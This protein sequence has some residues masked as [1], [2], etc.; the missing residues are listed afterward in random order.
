MS[1]L[2]RLSH[3]IRRRMQKFLLVLETARQLMTEFINPDLREPE[4]V[5]IPVEPHPAQRRS[6]QH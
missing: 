4:Y 3:W 2:K 1:L 6:R 5:R